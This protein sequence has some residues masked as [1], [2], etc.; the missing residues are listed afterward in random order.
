[1]IIP[2]ILKEVLIRA[3]TNRPG[4]GSIDCSYM[5]DEDFNFYFEA[6]KELQLFGIIK[7]VTD[8]YDFNPEENSF[9]KKVVY[10]LTDKGI[11]CKEDYNFLQE[12]IKQT[13]GKAST[14]LTVNATRL[15]DVVLQ[16]QIPEKFKTDY[17]KTI[18]EIY[19]CAANSCLIATIALCGKVL[20]YT[21][22][23]I[24]AD[25]RNYH[26]ESTIG[27][28]LPIVQDVLVKDNRYFDQNLMKVAKI[29]NYSRNHAIHSSETVPVPSE[30]QATMVVAAVTDFINRTL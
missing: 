3:G 15:R 5:K 12:V 29:V 2:E 27:Q 11:R 4:I 22:K 16:K 8:E 6:L 21:S 17:L 14:P 19:T 30:E 23:Y 10:G 9:D 13:E 20:E 24:I 25:K 7:W 18:D 26:P 28:L 1:M